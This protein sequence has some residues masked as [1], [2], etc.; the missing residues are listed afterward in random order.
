MSKQRHASGGFSI[1]FDDASPPHQDE[2]PASSLLAAPA[3]Y[4]RSNLGRLWLSRA[5][6]QA[7]VQVEHVLQGKLT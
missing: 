5:E 2:R 1:D 7:L 3:A 4:S 6:A